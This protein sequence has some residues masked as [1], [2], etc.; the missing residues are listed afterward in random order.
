[1]YGSFFGH[2]QVNYLVINHHEIDQRSPVWLISA[3]TRLNTSAMAP[4]VPSC[5]Q[6]WL[7]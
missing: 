4:Q 6:V 7:V 5:L 2:V 1:M 3:G